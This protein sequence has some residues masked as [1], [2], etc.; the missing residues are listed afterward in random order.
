MSHGP[1]RLHHVP[2][3]R[4]L[5]T[6]WLLHE[7]DLKFELITYSLGPA[8]RTPDYLARHPLGRVPCLED[9]ERI[10][11][12]SGAICEYLCE[13]RDHRGLWRPPGHPE[14]AEWLQYLHFSETITAH[15]ANLTQQHIAIRD[16]ADRSP[17]V[18]KLETLRLGKALGVLEV[19]L[20]N[21][22]YL[23]RGGFSAVDIAVGYAVYAARHF[24]RL[25]PLPAV[26]RYFERLS[27]RAAFVDALPDSE[28]SELL[29][30][31]D[32]YPLEPWL[33]E[34]DT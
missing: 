2:Q 7:L 29:F 11:I 6:L 22:D 20:A 3:S 14:R 31:R 15:I 28:T 18:M 4:S 10:L 24:V 9:G 5:R 30:A 25:D 1:L 13:T 12:E 27:C 26:S 23:L 33:P 16:D 17:M 19:V 32:F 21:R 8:L 34:N